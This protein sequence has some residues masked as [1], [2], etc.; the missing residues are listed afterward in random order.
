MTNYIAVSGQSIYDVC[1]NTYM[2]LNFLVKLMQDSNHPN[3]DTAP[4]GG[5]IF[6]F[7]ETLIQDQNVTGSN[8]VNNIIYSTSNTGGR[9][10]L[11]TVQGN[12]NGSN[13]NDT[14]SAPPVPPNQSSMKYYQQT[15]D[16]EYTSNADGTTSFT[17]PSLA[18][19]TLAIVQSWIEIQ[20]LKN[21]QIGI[22]SN[23]GKVTLSGG[24]VVDNGQ[25]F[26]LIYTI[27]I[28]Q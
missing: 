11:S 28:S 1:L 21:T 12:P 8:N 10:V 7:D 20:P 25:T 13:G 24:A 27:I 26:Y 3:V 23:T 22:D 17:L 18:N 16:I 2:S 9:S 6:V 14:I 15:L 19:K 5:Q 4:Y